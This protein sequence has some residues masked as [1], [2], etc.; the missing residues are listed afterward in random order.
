MREAGRFFCY[1]RFSRSYG[2]LEPLIHIRHPISVGERGGKLGASVERR[3]L[4]TCQLPHPLV[5]E[6]HPLVLRDR[7]ED[8]AGK[9]RQ[10][11]YRDKADREDGA[12]ELR[13]EAGR[14][15]IGYHG[16]SSRHAEQ[17]E[18]QREEQG[19]EQGVD[20]LADCLPLVIAGDDDGDCVA[21]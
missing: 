4:L 11:P 17:D 16:D 8:D 3:R 19:E 1:A 2:E 9:H 7:V 14:H 21:V 5:L 15:V 18:E 12:W 20:D 6:P 13:D 10:H